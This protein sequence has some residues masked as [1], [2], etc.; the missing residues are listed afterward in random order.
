MDDTALIEAT[1]AGNVEAFG[2]LV[3][4]Y[5]HGLVAAARHLTRNAEDAEDLAQEALVDAYTPSA[6][7]AGSREIPRLALRHPAPQMPQ[8]SPASRAGAPAHRRVCRIAARAGAGGRAELAELLDGLPLEYREI[9]AARYV[10]E[11]SY[12]EIAEVLGTTE[13]RCAY[14]VAVRANACANYSLHA[15]WKEVCHAEAV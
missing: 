10:Q 15:N 5:Q 6:H 9:L 1:L 13:M 4:K 3:G 14:A 2:V 7:P 11:L 8:R 12:A